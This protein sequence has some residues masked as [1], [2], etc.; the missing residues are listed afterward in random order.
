MEKIVK[1]IREAE[2]AMS[3]LFSCVKPF[4]S[5]LDKWTDDI[6]RDKYDHNG[7]Q[8]SEQPDEEEFIK[9]FRYQRER[10]DDFIR[11][12]G[13][14]PLEDPFSLEE[15]I[16]LTMLLEGSFENWCG[17]KDIYF[18]RPSLSEIQELD[19]KHFGESYGEDFCMRNAERQYGTVEYIGA[20]LDGKIAGSC[21]YFSWSGLVCVDGLMVDTE[22]RNKKIGTG[23]LKE[24]G[25]RNPNSLMFLHADLDDT[26]KEMYKAL[27]FRA[28]DR[29]YDYLLSGD[30]I[31][32]Y[33]K[34][35]L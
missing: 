2:R 6:L 9:A 26:P 18:K 3:S 11:L 13:Y 23:I 25:S 27:G 4:S 14:S 12:F 7:F 34:K 32:S 8:Y 19:V 28:V 35:Y 21:Y 10:G 1:K 15:D 30:S 31:I 24:I 33:D 17:N 20:Y 22:F 16:C 5:H 29:S